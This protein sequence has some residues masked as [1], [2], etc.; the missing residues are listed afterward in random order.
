MR[1]SKLE[2]K[3][4]KSFAND[5]VL[6][7]NEQITGIVGPNGSGKSNIVDAIR[8]VL[9]EQKSAEL[10]SDKSTNVIFNGSKN[11]KAAPYAKVSLVFENSRSILP[12]EFPE[13]AISREVYQ[14]GD[15][16]YK[17][18]NTVCRLKDITGLFA[19]TGVGS[20]TYAIIG[21]GMVEE[22]LNNRDNHR[23]SMLEQT[24]GIS[25]FKIRKKESLS[26]LNSTLEDLEQVSNLLAEVESNMAI[27]KKQAKR[28]EKF[29]FIRKE[30][31][32][33]SLLVYLNR[34]QTIQHDLTG[35]KKALDESMQHYLDLERNITTQET[36]LE[37]EKNTHLLEE[38]KISELQRDLN[39]VSEK[40]KSLENRKAL[41]L[42]RITFTN[43]QSE[44]AKSEI[45]LAHKDLTKSQSDLE[46]KILLSPALEATVK[47]LNEKSKSLDEQRRIKLEY[48]SGLDVN[49]KPVIEAYELTRRKILELEKQI[50]QDQ[51][52][53]AGYL[54]NQ[55]KNLQKIANLKV[56]IQLNET[57][58]D[59]LNTEYI[60][61]KSALEEEKS[62]LEQ[63][64][65]SLS[66]KKEELEILEKSQN[67]LKL[68]INTSHHESKTI[69][70]LIANMEGFPEAVRFIHS[71]FT[72]GNEFPI[73]AEVI[74][75]EEQF[76]PLVENFLSTKLSAYVVNTYLEAIRFIQQL[77]G[78][79]K[80]RT[81]F[82]ILEDY[83]NE[84][85][86]PEIKNGITAS[87]VIECSPLYQPLITSLFSQTYFVDSI[88]KEIIEMVKANPDMTC[89][90]LDGTAFTSRG[91]IS[92]GSK[93]LEEGHMVGRKKR[94]EKIEI[95]LIKL[96][97]T[98]KA[99]EKTYYELNN[100]IK[101]L[102]N[103]IKD[104]S[105]NNLEEKLRIA[106][107]RLYEQ[108]LALDNNKQQL[109]ISETDISESN[110]KLVN[111]NLRIADQNKEKKRLSEQLSQ[112]EAALNNEKSLQSEANSSLKE[113]DDHIKIVAIENLKA[114]HELENLQKDI[115][116]LSDQVRKTKDN[117]S[118]NET[119]I[120]NVIIEVSQLSNSIQELE[121]QVVAVN[122]EMQT[123]EK[124]FTDIE[125][126][127]YEK[128][129]KISEYEDQLRKLNRNR[130]D[131]NALINELKSKLQTTEFEVQRLKENYS[132]EF[133]E[134]P[135][136][137]PVDNSA[138]DVDINE[139]S[140]KQQSLKINLAN[141][142]EI[143]PLALQAYEE[144]KLRHQE[145]CSQR[146]DILLAKESL[147]STIKEIE[148]TSTE[149]Y[150]EVFNQ[151]RSN[152]RLVFRQ[153]FTEDDDCDLVLENENDPLET[154][155]S[156]IAKPKG[157][158]PQSLSQLSGGEKTL[159][160]IAFLFALYLIKPAP[161]CVFDE[162]DAPLD[163]VNVEK[164]LQLINKFKETSQFII[165][166][167]NKAT[168][169]A[170]DVLYGV[171]MEVQGVSGLS[172]VDFRSYDH[173]M[174]LDKVEN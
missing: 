156:I 87:S 55:E 82:Y 129:K 2:L 14:N 102:S 28:A 117:I 59:S 6:Y 37:T 3:G 160:A 144:I 77:E 36:L 69:R 66:A 72:N 13:V 19:D 143:N 29:N 161:F 10:R 120:S 125:K 9:G 137:T 108:Q 60:K 140:R 158:K 25:K 135:D 92:G 93:S 23:R 103:T 104:H 163:D 138:I 47:G 27:F 45:E 97:S 136:A 18:N 162:I 32:E 128:R 39:S 139:I 8:W 167:H 4:F 94:L 61:A 12:I 141:F 38:T 75:T 152:F 63:R 173:V 109:V 17:I 155:I 62:I 126:V 86:T 168:M 24:A 121:D 116:L 91:F 148:T 107:K 64:N 164:L 41:N 96:E 54:S 90:A 35:L 1:F 34:T 48:I 57:A 123:K 95:E 73:L 142:G 58:M 145:I 133:G 43:Q 67:A 169:A 22:L 11:K 84:I 81:G 134:L 150:L 100:E 119:L 68:K 132:L 70:S 154:D 65:I 106:E 46:Q 52:T 78:A 112:E 21:F 147:L 122:A 159:T 131:Q 26:K 7:F 74:N 170:M 151:V 71:L 76:R 80:G 153:L 118:V 88:S 31:Q 5:T 149:K 165:I 79:G 146:D 166:T 33:V 157:K 110:E 174:V 56:A 115:H 127:Y 130:N 16:V 53:I 111:L 20:N 113:L 114:S 83:N 44:K 99:N 105:L 40:I 171:Y 50:A 89:I 15:S 172:K 101:T 51:G 85:F 42:Q 30:Y 98:F 49:I 124:D